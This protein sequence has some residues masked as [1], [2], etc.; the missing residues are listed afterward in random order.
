MPSRKD[1]NQPNATVTPVKLIEVTPATVGKHVIYSDDEGG[2]VD[3]ETPKPPKN[4]EKVSRELNMV[5]LGGNTSSIVMK[6]L[7]Q[8]T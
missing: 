5:K 2:V 6:P 7:S 3:A 8:I 4:S 1:R